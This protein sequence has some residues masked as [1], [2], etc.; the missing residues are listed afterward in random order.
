MKQTKWELYD[1]T[2]DKCYIGNRA[3]IEAVAVELLK[4]GHLI[5]IGKEQSYAD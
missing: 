5:R 4:Q 1:L 3:Q 2:A